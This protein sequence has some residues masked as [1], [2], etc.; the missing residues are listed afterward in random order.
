MKMKLFSFNFKINSLNKIFLI[1]VLIA[2]MISCISCDYSNINNSGTIDFPDISTDSETSFEDIPKSGTLRLWMQETNNFNPLTSDQFHFHQISNL[3]Y[4]S[5][6]VIDENQ[7]PV[8]ILAKDI[9]T[10]PDNKVY[11]VNLKENILF[12]DGSILN[13]DDVVST[14]EFIK[15]PENSSK[16]SYLFNNIQD[17][18]ADGEYSVK[19]L[20]KTPDPFFI[21]KLTFPI[22]QKDSLDA[23]DSNIYPGTGVYNIINISKNDGIDIEIFNNHTNASLYKIQRIKVIFLDGTRSAMGAF[24]DDKIDMVFLDDSNF[25]IYRF[26]NDVIISKFP[27]N[28]FMFLEVNID[29][30]NLL[31]EKNK[32][33]Y[34]KDLLKYTVQNKIDMELIHYSDFPFY[35]SLFCYEIYEL[36]MQ[37][38]INNKELTNNPFSQS[39][40]SIKFVYNADDE[41]SFRT[42]EQIKQTFDERKI[43]IQ[44]IAADK[45][46]Y[47]ELVEERNYDIILRRAVLDNNPDPSW[48][49]IADPFNNVA[50]S[51][52]LK[53]PTDHE[54]YNKVLMNFRKLYNNN[55]EIIS[56]DEFS[57]MLIEISELSPYVGIGFRNNGMMQSN[58]V[59]GRMRSNSSNNYNDI[60]DVW[61]WSGQ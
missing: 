37:S 34:V 44:L 13:S 14:V 45:D 1:F 38:D 35:S 42:A 60:E 29:K 10:E 8:M 21:F 46:E 61:I 12:H 55:Y 5:L 41:F 9:N 56:N 50:G 48:L 26:R 47:D 15:D 53:Y 33:M 11:K 20:L 18:I 59:R 51:D 25:E 39:D 6:V 30:G 58:R 7:E 57:N 22:L 54:E 24:S 17:V 3:I 31:H 28:T 4:E 40:S 32:F 19:F 52:T 23:K 27:G 2:L 36:K 43:K 49:Y 16:F